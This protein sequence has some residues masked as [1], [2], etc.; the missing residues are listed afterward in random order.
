MITRNIF[1]T[2]FVVENDGM[3]F[4]QYDLF[5]SLNRIRMEEKIC[6]IYYHGNKTRVLCSHTYINI[7]RFDNKN[8]ISTTR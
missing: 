2:A 5:V 1:R 6:F 3:L 8:T 4:L 7:Y